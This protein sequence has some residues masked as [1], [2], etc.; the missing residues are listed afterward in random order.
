ML[1]KQM[2]KLI[3]GC[4]YLGC[5]VAKRWLQQGHTVHALKRGRE[6]ELKALGIQPIHGDVRELLDVIALPPAGTVLYAV[7]PGRDEGQTPDDVWLG[8]LGNVLGAF[9]KRP[10]QPRLIF[11]S[12]TSVYGQTDGEEIDESA[13][14]QPREEAGQ[15]L[16]RA[17]GFLGREWPEAIILRFAAIYGPGRLLRSKAIQAGEPLVAD[18]EKW[19]NLIHVDDG[20]NAVL[21]AEAHGKPGCI[22]N[23]CDGQPVRRREFYSK[24]AEVLKVPPPRF[25]LPSP[26]ALLPHETTNR[27]ICNR[28]MCEE[29][30]V[31]LQYPNYDAGLRDSVVA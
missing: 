17:E 3:V 10:P 2:D 19:L 15:A 4:G 22:Y 23:I 14:T 6:A 16:L 5:R 1:R 25:I 20:A 11:I 31:E 13:P 30:K 8:G 12:S 18:P 7:A 27:R 28:R 29:L 21:A 26:D 9:A 24:M